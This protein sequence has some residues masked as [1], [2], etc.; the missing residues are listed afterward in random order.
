MTQRDV[1]CAF[2]GASIRQRAKFISGAHASVCTDCA[3]RLLDRREFKTEGPACGLCGSVKNPRAVTGSAAACEK[4]L[5]KI[6]DVVYAEQSP[7]R[8][9]A[10]A[11]NARCVKCSRPASAAT[12]VF[13]SLAY[14]CAECGKAESQTLRATRASTHHDACTV[15]AMVTART[16]LLRSAISMHVC[17]V[18]A[19]AAQSAKAPVKDDDVVPVKCA[20]CNS[21]DAWRVYVAGRGLFIC[22]KCVTRGLE[23]PPRIHGPDLHCR[24]C[25]RAR[26][27][28]P[29]L[30]VSWVQE[31]AVICRTCLE[32]ASELVPKAP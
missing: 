29:A 26:S 15:C 19:D 11:V 24:F 9:R 13:G 18:C 22:G 4:C 23:E 6:R 10:T 16:G 27:E 25:T 3:W 5:L 14:L 20:F 32:L 2:C 12:P 21:A 8:P 1:A 30:T 31:D 7:S 28:V 17:S